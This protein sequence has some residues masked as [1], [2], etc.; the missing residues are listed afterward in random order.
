MQKKKK[1]QQQSRERCRCTSS[2]LQYCPFIVLHCPAWS[3]ACTPS[4]WGFTQETEKFQIQA[5][6]T[7]STLFFPPPRQTLCF[8]ARQQVSSP[9]RQAAWGVSAS[10]QRW[11]TGLCAPLCNARCKHSLG[12]IM[13]LELLSSINSCFTGS[14]PH[15]HHNNM[16]QIGDVPLE[17][18]IFTADCCIFHSCWVNSNWNV[19]ASECSMLFKVSTG[20]MLALTNSLV[21]LPLNSTGARTSLTVL[22]I[23]LSSL[24]LPKATWWINKCRWYRYYA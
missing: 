24:N 6:Y 10:W 4:P 1:N 18:L 3:S 15:L 11:G 12:H 16:A 7:K 14:S 2:L 13:P 5:R 8:M 9:L 22:R 17:M 19:K 23:G 20:E 21:K